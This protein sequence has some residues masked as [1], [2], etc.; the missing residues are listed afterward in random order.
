MRIVLVPNSSESEGGDDFGVQSHLLYFQRDEPSIARMEIH[1]MAV[2]NGFNY[3]SQRG[4]GR[5]FR[6]AHGATLGRANRRVNS[7]VKD[8]HGKPWERSI[9]KWKLILN[10][11]KQ[12]QRS[13]S[14]GRKSSGTKGCEPLILCFLD[15]L[16]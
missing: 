16:L 10:R 1:L 4:V 5:G 3:C 15:Y 6:L 2:N 13:K 14:R 8:L 7:F 11:S 12:S 9:W